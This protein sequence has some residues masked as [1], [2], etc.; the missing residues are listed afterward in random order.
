[1]RP[2]AVL[3]AA[4]GDA[5]KFYSGLPYILTYTK[6]KK[7]I[8]RAYSAMNE[9]TRGGFLILCLSLPGRVGLYQG[10]R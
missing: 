6:K 5:F 2:L 3:P 9:N 10:R 1:M 7:K 8:L 4:Y